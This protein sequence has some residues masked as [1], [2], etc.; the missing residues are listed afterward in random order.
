VVCEAGLLCDGSNLDAPAGYLPYLS[1]SGLC[2]ALLTCPYGSQC[3]LKDPVLGKGI[4]SGQPANGTAFVVYLGGQQTTPSCGGTLLYDASRVDLSLPA[5]L[6]WDVLYWL[7]PTACGNGS[8]LLGSQCAKCPAGTSSSN[9]LA[10]SNTTCVPC[11]AGTIAP[12]PG[13][14]ACTACTSGAFMAARG[15]SVCVQ[16]SAGTFQDGAQATACKACLPGSYTPNLG[17][18][19]CSLCPAGTSQPSSGS[20]GCLSCASDQFSSAGDPACSQCGKPITPPPAGVTCPIQTLPDDTP[21]VW[22]SVRGLQGDEC[23]GIAPSVVSQSSVTVQVFTNSTYAK[24]VTSM[25]VMGLSSVYQAW[26]NTVISLQKPASIQVYAYNQTVYPGLCARHGFGV[27]FTVADQRGWPWTDLTGAYAQMVVLGSGLTLSM[28][29][30]ES[31]PGASDVVGYGTCTSA[32]FCPTMNVTVQVFLTIPG[33]QIIGGSTNLYI[34]APVKPCLPTSGPAYIAL[35]LLNANGPFLPGD[36]LN[37]QVSSP[38][39]L[40]LYKGFRFVLKMG[41]QVDFVSFSS[42]LSLT[43]AMSNAMLSVSGVVSMSDA[44]S[45]VLG[46][47][48][49]KLLNATT[50]PMPV[51]CPVAGS[52]AFTDMQNM[53]VAAT[54]LAS[55]VTCRQDGCLDAFTDTGA[56]GTLLAGAPRTMLINWQALFQNAPVTTTSVSVVGIG[57]VVGQVGPV[58][59]ASCQALSSSL[60]ATSCSSVRPQGQG[61]GDPNAGLSVSY[62]GASTVLR[63]AVFVPQTPVVSSYTGDTGAN[64]R[65]KL[66]TT[67][68]SGTTQIANV[69]AT[70]FV[71]PDAVSAGLANEQWSCQPGFIGSF[72]LFGQVV[73]SCTGPLAFASPKLTLLTGFQQGL[74]TIQFASPYLAAGQATGLLLPFTG[75]T[76]LKLDSA[77]SLAPWSTT[78]QGQTATM[79]VSGASGQCAVVQLVIRGVAWQLGIPVYPPGPV[80]LVMTLGRTL[81]V[82]SNDHT[83]LLPSSTTIMQVGLIVTENDAEGKTM[84]SSLDQEYVDVTNDPRLFLSG[85]LLQINGSNVQALSTAGTGRIQAGLMGI[86]CVQTNFSVV[87][88]SAAVVSSTLICTGC[89]QLTAPDDP[90]SQDFPSLFPSAMDQSHFT[91]SLTLADGSTRVVVEPLTVTGC[92]KLVGG[93]LMTTCPGLANVSTPSTVQTPIQLRVLSRWG[94]N[95]SLTCNGG[96]CAGLNLAPPGD[97][98]TLPPFAYGSALSLG[99]V[100]RLVN[101]STMPATGLGGLTL[102]ANGIATDGANLQLRYGPLKIDYS[103]TSN[104]GLVGGT[105]WLAVSRFQSLNILGPAVLYQLHCSRLWQEAAYST[106]ITLSDGNAS[107]VTSSLSAAPPLVM[108]A[109]GLFHADWAGDGIITAT[110]GVVTGTRTI[111]ATVSSLFFSAISLDSLPATWH[112][113]IGDSIRLSAT[114]WPVY[115]TVP[116]YNASNLTDLVMRWACTPPGVIVFGQDLGTLSSQCYA[117]VS[118]TASLVSC[119]TFPGANFS[120]NITVDVVPTAAGQVVLG[121]ASGKPLS[122]AKVGDTVGMQV[123][124]LATNSLQVTIFVIFLRFSSIF[125]HFFVISTVLAEFSRRNLHIRR[126]FWRSRVLV[127][128]PAALR[129]QFGAL[130]RPNRLS[131]CRRHAPERGCGPDCDG[132]SAGRGA[133]QRAGHRRDHDHTGHDRHT[134]PARGRQPPGGPV[135][136]WRERAPLAQT[137]GIPAAEPLEQAPAGITQ[138]GL[139]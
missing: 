127:V 80:K 61:Q 85:Y 107:N 1:A 136:H 73:G 14:A 15:G 27:L 108:H 115:A 16:C 47:L 74:G 59:G 49:V 8:F 118:V 52:L 43:T 60:L 37:V 91:V 63:L 48:Q 114:L 17:Q 72:S 58:S 2:T 57:R 35:T 132:H 117:P 119:Q 125:M 54:P 51:V 126:C 102:L 55:G 113:P 123:G 32:T 5:A 26:S 40:A 36:V 112:A 46:T 88:A 20:S 65:Y 76:V 103:F 13:M 78:V 96:P 93:T 101:G 116:W 121:S 131:C 41:L 69:D 4:L 7:S 99:V 22:V 66:F 92:L 84:D 9:Q 86:P 31:L 110:F 33:G 25:Y 68:Q 79:V 56:V 45:S 139:G 124:I 109:P 28:S 81:L 94:V 12:S 137:A 70:P 6:M 24:C 42:T 53:Y 90:L 11:M 71:G 89:P 83:G 87:I 75:K 138:H 111:T 98:A 106:Q 133:A 120:K 29:L 135:W 50:S 100:I 67:L 3:A 77:Q 64:G 44:G 122:D 34:A 128:G 18:T 105:A 39:G 97:P 82:S 95:A 62:Q 38:G 30:C 104:W 10:V 134:E 23:L 21:G 129:V 130:G 19:V